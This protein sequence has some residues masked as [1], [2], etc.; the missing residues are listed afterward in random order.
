MLEKLQKPKT[1]QDT[2]IQDDETKPDSR[3]VVNISSTVITSLQVQVLSKGLSF[4]PI[5][6][7]DWFQLELDFVQFLRRLKLRIW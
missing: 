1:S 5:M 6:E 7:P 3:T 2:N 4:C